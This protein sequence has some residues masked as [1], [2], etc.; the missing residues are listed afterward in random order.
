M[1]VRRKNNEAPQNFDSASRCR[2]LEHSRE[3]LLAE[4][5]LLHVR[6]HLTIGFSQCIRA[7]Y[8][9]AVEIPRLR[10]G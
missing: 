1:V 2:H 9:S 10:S 7:D 8:R 6:Q 5:S 3:I 4:R